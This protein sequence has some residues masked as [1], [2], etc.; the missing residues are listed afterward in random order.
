MNLSI[1]LADKEGL[2]WAQEQVAAHHY[3]HHPVDVRCNPVAYRVLLRR[4]PVG[5]LIFGRPEATRVNGWYGSVEDVR[6]GRCPLTRWQVLN[7]ARVWL[8]P[9][10]Q[11][12]GDC[13]I[14][15]AASW[16][17]AQAMRRIVYDYLIVK[18]P[19]WMEEP[20][21]IRECLSY[22]DSR[23]HTGALYRAANFRLVRTNAR[24]IQTYTRPL[25]RLT[26]VEI[27]HIRQRSASDARGGK[28]R[29]QR[30]WLQLL[31]EATA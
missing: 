4:A 17:I 24:G 10:V 5:C 7:L 27:A 21:E 14:A 22:C 3:L 30:A 23:L 8:H 16:V 1:A 20:Y 18:P 29:T 13:Y 25:R 15:N 28:L 2:A 11:H 12:G 19:V 6:I 26:R 9:S 31:E